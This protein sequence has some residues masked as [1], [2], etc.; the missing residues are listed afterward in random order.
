MRHHRSVRGRILAVVGVVALASAVAVVALASSSANGLP[1][2][3][4]GYAKWPRINSKPFTKCGPPC[5]HSGVKNVYAS[6][7][8]VGKKYPNGTVIVKSIRRSGDKASLPGQVAVMRKANGRWRF[9]EYQLSGSRYTVLAQG[10]LCQ[11]CHM[12]AR[13]NDYVFTKR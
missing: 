8:K 4:N 11:S 10:Q 13:A 2:Y 3:T 12:Q 7:R 6:K 9:V 5:A 1:S